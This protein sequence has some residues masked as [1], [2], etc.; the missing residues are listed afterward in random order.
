[1]FNFSIISLFFGSSK[2]EASATDIHLDMIK[3]SGEKKIYF[4]T[5]TYLINEELSDRTC[6]PHLNTNNVRNTLWY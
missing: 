1:M 6:V 2:V 4:G 5:I 3:N